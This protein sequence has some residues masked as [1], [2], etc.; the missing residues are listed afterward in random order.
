MF[1]GFVYLWLRWRV[2]TNFLLALLQMLL[3]PGL[4]S[5]E[6]PPSV[7]CP[8]GVKLDSGARFKGQEERGLPMAK[9]IA[10]T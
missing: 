10:F 9:Y 5:S 6:K 7:S 3:S 4:A 2:M 1:G 8:V